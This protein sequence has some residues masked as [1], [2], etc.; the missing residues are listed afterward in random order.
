M[1]LEVSNKLTRM[2]REV[3]QDAMRKAIMECSK[4]YGFSEEEAL[5]KLNVENLRIRGKGKKVKEGKLEGK[6]EGEKSKYPLPYNNEYEEK[7]CE[8]VRLNGGLYTQCE[9]KKK[10]LSKYCNGC[11]KQASKNESEMPEYGTI[12]MRL[13]KKIMEYVDPKGR[14][15]TPY[16]KIMKRLNITKEEVLEEASRCGKLIDEIHFE[17]AEQRRGRPATIKEKVAKGV[18]GRPKK[19]KKVVEITGEAEDLFSTLVANAIEE[20]EKE[21]STKVEAN[22]EANTE[23]NVEANTEANVEANVEEKRKEKEEKR[24]EKEEKRK[25][26]ELKEK[27]KEE[28]RKEKEHKEKEKEEKRKEKELKEKEKEE[29]RKEKELKEKEK[30]EKR[31]EKEL[32]EKEKELKE[33]EKEQREEKKKAKEVVVEKKVEVVEKEVVEKKVEEVEK[34]VVENKVEEDKLKKM[35][36]EGKKYLVSRTTG[37]IYDL[38]KHLA[39]ETV[40]LGKYDE[41]TKEYNFNKEESSSESSEESEE[42]EDEYEY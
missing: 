27:E 15:P 20:E 39:G 34:E 32:K 36:H 14:K 19:T 33:K 11:G 24:K 10:E 17:E 7:C 22:T 1:S 21:V 35:S 4:E 28:K 3:A 29:K 30:E 8:A 40:V 38:E 13:E 12:Q 42:S 26:K 31:K 6:L 9:N 5:R 37:I 23:A 2:L 41:K 18:K 25:E 16:I